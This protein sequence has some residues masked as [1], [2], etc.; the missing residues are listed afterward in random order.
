M[1]T[2]CS[3]NAST[4]DLTT[5]TFKQGEEVAA[6]SRQSS[7]LYG[8]QNVKWLESR[9]TALCAKTLACGLKSTPLNL[10]PHS[11]QHR[12]QTQRHSWN[13][14]VALNEKYWYYA[15]LIL[16]ITCLLWRSPL[17][18]HF[19]CFHKYCFLVS[20]GHQYCEWHGLMERFCPYRWEKIWFDHRTKL[21]AQTAS[22][23]TFCG[24]NWLVIFWEAFQGDQ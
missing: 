16:M 17:V 13:N 5:T 18:Y 23:Q 12:R 15:V 14:D 7:C 1:W 9:W 4:N 21:S 22:F 6:E 20:H 10:F 8:F 19:Y 11:R 24:R 2:H 3:Y